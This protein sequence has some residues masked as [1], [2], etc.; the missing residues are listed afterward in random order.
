MNAAPP[1]FYRR[2]VRDDT[3]VDRCNRAVMHVPGVFFMETLFAPAGSGAEKGNLS[4]A[5]Q[6]RNCQFFTPETRKTTHFF[7]NYLHDYDL[8]DPT[9]ARSL[10]ASMVEGFMEDKA[11]IENQQ[12]VLECRPRVRHASDRRRRRAGA[13]PA[14]AVA[15]DRRRAGHVAGGRRLSGTAPLQRCCRTASPRPITAIA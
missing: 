15:A 11:I 5:K 9:I 10:H 6:Y 4:Q 14:H 8:H 1:P 7:W 2:V 13:F 12:K 3:P